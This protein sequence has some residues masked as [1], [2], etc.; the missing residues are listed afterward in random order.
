MWSLLKVLVLNK[1]LGIS[2][3][4]VAINSQGN[5][6]QRITV[7]GNDELTKMTMSFNSMLEL[8]EFTQEQLQYRIS[9]RTK[10]LDKLSSLNHNLFTEISK[11]KDIEAK[12]REDEK[13]LRQLAYYDSLTDLPN[14][15]FFNELLQQA[16]PNAQQNNT[17]IAVML[18]DID[19]FKKINKTYSQRFG[20]DLLQQVAAYL[21]SSIK[22]TDIV[23]RILGDDFM[24]FLTNIKDKQA[25]E[26]AVQAIFQRFA[27]G[28][29]INNI[30]IQPTLSIGISIYPD[31]G[32]AIK[33][34]I[35][36]IDLA[37]FYAK[38]QE[39]NSYRYYADIDV[40][41]TIGSTSDA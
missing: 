31:D 32:K 30:P 25:I 37:M 24:L 26:D 7:S 12:M 29:I 4:V 36:Q 19:N 15:V 38:K 35:K 22:D 39:G 20:D 5:F 28:F 11:Q 16:I 1:I 14:Q 10:D 40:T 33:D 21:K 27:T 41:H 34:L 23:G 8:I 9:R 2:K 13:T 18:L 3:Q 6:Y 17:K